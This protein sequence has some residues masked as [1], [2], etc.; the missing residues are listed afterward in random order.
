MF[1]N[2]VNVF[3]KQVEN[4][5]IVCINMLL[6]LLFQRAERINRY[7]QKVRSKFGSEIST[8]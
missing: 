8:V 6:N 2:G 3:C 5:Y 7:L 4:K 1:V